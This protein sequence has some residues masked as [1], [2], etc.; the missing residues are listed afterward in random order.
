MRIAGPVIAAMLV[1][2][3]CSGTETG[4][5]VAGDTTTTSSTTTTTTGS[6]PGDTRPKEIDMATLDVCGLVSKLPVQQF[7]IAADR[8]PVGGDSSIFPGSKDCY[9][10]D[11]QANLGLT[12]VAVATEGAEDYAASVSNAEVLEKE[13]AGYEVWVLKPT[14]PS[15]CLGAVDVNKGQLLFINY[16]QSR[17]GDQ[18]VTPQDQLCAKVPEIAAA[19]LGVLA[20]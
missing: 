15:G 18:P 1:L 19:A 16:G 3:G 17:P 7:G 12:L 8:P 11:I 6:E 9:T 14:D 5:P 13:A 10:N 20:G 4:T 2:A